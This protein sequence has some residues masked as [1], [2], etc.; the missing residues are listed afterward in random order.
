MPPTSGLPL[1]TWRGYRP[2]LTA[3]V[4]LAAIRRLHPRDVGIGSM[5]QMLGSRW[6]REALVRGDDPREI[7]R[8]WDA[9]NAEWNLVRDRYRL[10]P[11][12]EE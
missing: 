4:L 11:T 5:L 6:A 2:V 3:F 12:G 1:H 10:Y 8:R 7:V 9:E